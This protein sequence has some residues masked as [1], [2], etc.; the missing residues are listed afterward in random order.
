[1]PEYTPN[2]SIPFPAAGDPVRGSTVDYL[3][4]DLRD[5]AVAAD[6][7][8]VRT[9]ALA[10]RDA[11][12]AA[13][14][15]FAFTESLAAEE[16]TRVVNRVIDPRPLSP[17]E[18]SFAYGNASV[19]AAPG[20]GRLIASGGGA[21]SLIPRLM[22]DDVSVDP[23]FPV[24]PGQSIGFTVELRANAASK[25]SAT[26]TVRGYQGETLGAILFQAGQ[27]DIEPGA[28]RTFTAT[29]VVPSSGVDGVQVTVTF[30]RY[31]ETYPQAGDFLFWRNFAVYVG[32]VPSPVVYSDGD[33]EHS[34]WMAKPHES[35]SASMEPRRR[36]VSGGVQ[37]PVVVDA[38]LRRRGRAIGTQGRAFVS[39]RFDH[40][41]TPF[42]DKVLPLLREHRMPWGQMLNA[43]PI[44]AGTAGMTWGQIGQVC[45]DSGGEVWNHSLTHSEVRSEAEADRE[46]TQ[47][48]QDLRAGLP[49][50]WIDSWA[51]PGASEYMGYEG[52][53]TA[54]KH[55][56]TYT[57][58]LIVSQHGLVRGYYPG[59][60]RA[61]TGAGLIGQS[62]AVLDQQDPSWASGV[63]RGAIRASAGV[64]F[65]LHPNYLDQPGFMSTSELGEFFA[66]LAARRDAGEV[67]VL[68]PAG[69]LL[70]DTGVVSSPNLLSDAGPGEVEGEWS[71]TVSTRS[72]SSQYGVPHEA[73][74]WVRATAAGTVTLRVQVSAVGTS[75][76]QTHTI[77][78]SEGGLY[79]LGVPVTPPT[80]TTQ[81]VVTLAGGVS[82]TGI[83]YGAV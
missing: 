48:L 23:R 33:G 47:G 27:D 46:I 49:G 20:W 6:A 67:V 25:L 53:D 21:V 34:Y 12:T 82:H 79:R 17:G 10:V 78:A 59:L 41:L 9:H 40:H 54:E 28:R 35:A 39:L 5:L 58:Q 8:D 66:D 13:Q 81:T 3:R 57:G 62:H 51:P 37:R 68:S 60:Y 29:G 75:I 70:A 64:T 77:E 44:D 31:G 83:H 32:N 42:S 22:P 71:Q 4:T 63:L 45:H 16:G 36:G 7:A 19:I 73:V 26:V 43:G 61:P 80:S 76:D 69:F 15:R 74:A 1:M 38:A 52:M 11:A 24:T 18:D 72:A 2:S 55:Y 14:Q 30:R 50:L 56:D 65:M